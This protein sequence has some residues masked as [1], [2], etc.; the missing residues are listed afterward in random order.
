MQWRAIEILDSE[1]EHDKLS[2]TFNRIFPYFDFNEYVNN[3]KNQKFYAL[4]DE[5][6]VTE[7]LTLYRWPKDNGIDDSVYS[8]KIVKSEPRF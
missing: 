7:D 3:K 1:D 5:E 8:E 4:L 2:H 6:F